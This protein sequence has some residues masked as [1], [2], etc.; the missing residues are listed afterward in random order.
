LGS[1]RFKLDKIMDAYDTFATVSGGANSR[2]KNRQRRSRGQEPAERL[3]Q[4][5]LATFMV[6]PRVCALG[7]QAGMVPHVVSE[8]DK[9]RRA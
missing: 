6:S 3:R 5:P 9:S 7:I 1:H 2:S 4:Q 8:D